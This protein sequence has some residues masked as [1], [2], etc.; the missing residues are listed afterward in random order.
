LRFI[1]NEVKTDED[2]INLAYSFQLFSFKYL[3]KKLELSIKVLG[4]RPIKSIVMAGGV[5]SNRTLRSMLD[6]FGKH[7]SLKINYPPIELCSDNGVMV[8]WNGV[9]RL[10]RGL[11]DLSDGLSGK[12]EHIEPIAKWKLTVS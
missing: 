10:H 6:N 3:F 12:I 1:R 7:K 5:A 11:Y 8:A 9:E 2:K 4:D